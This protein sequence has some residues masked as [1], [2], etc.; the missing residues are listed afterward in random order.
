MTIN[1]E[2]LLELADR[3]EAAT[4]PDRALDREIAR[5]VLYWTKRE[6]ETEANSI[7]QFTASLDAAMTLV[8]EGYHP[9]WLLRKAIDDCL[10]AVGQSGEEC[11]RRLPAFVSAAC[12]RARAKLLS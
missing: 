12:L 10:I 7:L 6:I 4:G 9:S 1:E 2:G 3:C 11:V 5:T 8:P